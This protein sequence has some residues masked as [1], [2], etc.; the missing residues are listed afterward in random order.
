MSAAE[1]RR[2]HLREP[3]DHA[4]LLE[5]AATGARACR[6][7]DVSISGALVTSEAGLESARLSPGDVVQMRF[8]VPTSA[9]RDTGD[10]QVVS[11]RIVR[12]V[13][14]G[15]G[16]TFLDATARALGALR[17][18]VEVHRRKGPG[19]VDR[20]AVLKNLAEAVAQFHREQA[21]EFLRHLDVCLLRA[22]RDAV[23]DR[24]AR[25][26]TD[27]RR[28]LEQQRAGLLQMLETSV[29][30][31]LAER[32]QPAEI[33][34][35]AASVPDAVGDFALLDLSAF[36]DVLVARRCLELAE[37]G[38]PRLFHRYQRALA[39]LPPPRPGVHD[40]LDPETI[41]VQFAEVVQP[42]RLEA[43][44]RPVLLR[45]FE[46]ALETP[47]RELIARLIDL[48]PAV[49]PLATPHAPRA[50]AT[51]STLGGNGRPGA[52][53]ASA[54]GDHGPIAGGGALAA[55]GR[56][57][58]AAGDGMGA[59]PSVTSLPG[60]GLQP[61]GL[62]AAPDAAQAVTA[63]SSGTSASA[64]SGS[65][66]APASFS[67]PPGQVPAS[68]MLAG[69]VTP[70]S[71]PELPA[72]AP[73]ALA[74]R[75]LARQPAS[76]PGASG[77]SSPADWQRWFAVLAGRVE[78]EASGAAT[79]GVASGLYRQMLAEH[80]DLAARPPV[81]ALL[82]ALCLAEAHWE[83]LAV[84]PFVHPAVLAALGRL[85][86]W[87]HGWGLREPGWML[88]YDDPLAGLLDRLATLWPHVTTTAG[89]MELL[90]AVCRKLI[91]DPDASLADPALGQ[92]LDAALLVQRE[93]ARERIAA[94]V[95][96]SDE[97]CSNT[98]ARRRLVADPAARTADEAAHP[99]R[100]W[101]NLAQTWQ[102]GTRALL[103]RGKRTLPV[104]LAWI[105]PEAGSFVFVDPAGEAV[106]T[107]T[108]QEFAVN[109]HR[110]TLRRVEHPNAPL[111]L[112]LR[113]AVLERFARTVL[114]PTAAD[115]P[116]EASPPAAAGANGALVQ[117]GAEVAERTLRLTEADLNPD[118]IP[119]PPTWKEVDGRILE[120]EIASLTTDPAV[121]DN[122]VA[123][124]RERFLEVVS[125]GSGNVAAPHR[126]PTLAAA[127]M[128][129][130][131][132]R[133]L[134]LALWD[135]VLAL[136]EAGAGQGNWALRMSAD[137]LLA[138]DGFDAFQTRLLEAA[139]PPRR[140]TLV[141]DITAGEPLP[142]ALG[143]VLHALDSLGLRLAL[144]A[145]GATLAGWRHLPVER[146]WA[147]AP[148][149]GAGTAERDRLA[150]LADF[151][152][153]A[154]WPI[155][156]TVG[157]GSLSPEELASLGVSHLAVP[158]EWRA[159]PVIQ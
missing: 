17:R 63:F 151:A 69:I 152:R 159:L 35:A 24:D 5:H 28:A 60:I 146:L 58:A 14:N 122:G 44:A 29:S 86:A 104:E 116:Q 121:G 124:A 158:R 20:V 4:A 144:E 88:R 120:S 53:S 97:A 2:R 66:M 123:A 21:P 1:E 70:G 54:F 149:T 9:A 115:V 102:R 142:E 147:T 3:L 148:H 16:I 113:D 101:L 130:G 22:A 13:R 110:G 128:A 30:R 74:S 134:D 125:V 157:D 106:A 72:L 73:S 43:V 78:R 91:D 40:P 42:L 111:S 11:G 76:A 135:H 23:N 95:A 71:Y 140:L 118:P 7:R 153:W 154:E 68:G 25:V 145:T 37:R 114:E 112:R 127:L 33:S 94:L 67:F 105:D 61:G 64:R 77:A 49:S 117:S 52:F 141:I 108:R 131:V 119:A 132:R 156:A 90:D 39:L 79:G 129:A 93:R 26:L 51:G 6:L 48:M 92:M 126:V 82:E 100:H 136:A 85:R 81:G 133:R 107:M 150:V 139:V 32:I 75:L 55:S 89:L 15:L 80:A 87:M 96:A 50:R 138:A 34:V 59:Q 36:E 45:A 62:V 47:F 19:A 31:K 38:D 8:S 137:T 57:P 12:V 99:L 155:V 98:L 46:E 56:G 18:L 27:A 83:A 41:L 65:A 143:E 103:K 109:L 10:T 84:D